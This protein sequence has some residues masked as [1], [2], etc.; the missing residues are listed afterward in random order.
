MK[1]QSGFRAHRQTK[2]NLAF[3]IQKIQESFSR[4][5]VLAFFFD[6]SQA[7]DKVWHH[8]LINKL[9]KIKLPVK[10]IKWIADFLKDRSFSVHVDEFTT[11]KVPVKCGVPQEAVISPTLFSIYINDIP[12]MNIKN[13][14]YSLLFA[15]DLS[16]FFIFKK[17][18]KLN[19]I[20]ND[21][22]LSV[23]AWLSQYSFYQYS[24]YLFN[25]KIPSCTKIKFLGLTF[26]I[27]LSFK[28]HIQDIKKKCINRLNII[29]I[30]SNKA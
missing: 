14:S 11:S 20:V 1:Q 19:K 5:K 13:K 28:D 4:K 24:F 17:N 8:G 12:I 26:D 30:L 2:D 27:C 18:G 6:I 21:Y 16:T 29:K 15:H 22:I 9:I 25:E 3:L 7:F 10:L 23:E